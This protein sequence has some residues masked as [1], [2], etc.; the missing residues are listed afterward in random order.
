MKVFLINA[1][2]WDLY[3]YSKACREGWNLGVLSVFTTLSGLSNA[4]GQADFWGVDSWKLA[5]K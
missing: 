5:C 4:S 1:P 2:W 3:A